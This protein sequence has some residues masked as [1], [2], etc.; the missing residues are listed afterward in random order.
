VYWPLVACSYETGSLEVFERRVLNLAARVLS[1][2][3]V[4][5]TDFEERIKDE[6]EA[7]RSSY[8]SFTDDLKRDV[9]Q[10]PGRWF[11]PAAVLVGLAGA[12]WFVLSLLGVNMVA[13][14]SLIFSSFFAILVAGFIVWVTYRVI[15][16]FAGSALHRMWVRRTRKGALLH[17]RWWAFRRY[18]TDFSRM[19]ESPPASLA[20]WEQF[21]VYGIALGVAEQVI[22]AVR[23]KAPPEIAEGGSFYSPGYDTSIS[24]PTGFAFSDLED[25]FASAFTPPSSSSS[26]GG[27]SFSGGGGGG[28]GAW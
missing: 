6:R 20:L 27:G 3:P 23:L 26:G 24:G 16:R 15:S 10:S 4:S 18:L 12:A 9:E 17:A 25:R 5:L 7:N 22:E 19:E 8:E 11:G 1:R 21:L 28:G 13:L 2:G 14:F